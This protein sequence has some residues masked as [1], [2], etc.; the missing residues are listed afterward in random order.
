[1]NGL[2]SEP[3][4]Q[5]P[6]ASLDFEVGLLRG[7]SKSLQLSDHSVVCGRAQDGRQEL[8]QSNDAKV[9]RVSRLCHILPVVFWGITPHQ[10]RSGV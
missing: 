3:L 7:A 5:S 6:S 8:C 9:G 1:M 4:S 10:F 2:L